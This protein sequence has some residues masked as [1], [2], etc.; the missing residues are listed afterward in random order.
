MEVN[1]D[2]LIDKIFNDLPMAKKSITLSFVEDMELV[3]LFEFL[4]TV[5]TQGAKNLY[6]DS[7]G[8][9][10]LDMCTDTELDIMNKYCE[11]IGFKVIIDKYDPSDAQYIDFN[12]MYYKNIKITQ[13]TV[14]RELHL[15]MHCKK[16]IY[17]LTFD[18]C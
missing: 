1:T 3:D 9:V 13:Q 10:N 11:S 16:N 14:L 4:L 5:F 2:Q 17:V 12:A 7:K 6:G 18:Y 15:T 8:K